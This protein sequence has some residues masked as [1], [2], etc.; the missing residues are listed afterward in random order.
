MNYALYQPFSYP[1]PLRSRIG[2]DGG[3]YCDK[4]G[5]ILFLQLI[6]WNSFYYSVKA[7]IFVRLFSCQKVFALFC[8]Q[9]DKRKPTAGFFKLHRLLYFTRAVSLTPVVVITPGKKKISVALSMQPPVFRQ[10][11]S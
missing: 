9:S 8:M 1:F 4:M 5:L 6:L 11:E 7:I 2:R 3:L 10:K